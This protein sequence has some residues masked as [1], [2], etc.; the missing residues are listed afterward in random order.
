MLQHTSAIRGYAIEA[1]D[2][3]VGDITDFLVDD[4]T[5][6]MRWLVADTGGFLG[7]RKVL[8]PPSALG[9]V[10]HLGRRLS[11][12][13]TLRQVEDSPPTRSDEPVSRVMEANIYAYY[14][15][16]PYWSTGFDVGED[17]YPAGVTTR[18]DLGETP[19]DR[20]AS[21]ERRAG[22]DERLRSVREITGYHIH[23][24]DGGIGHVADFLI[25][26]WDWRIRYLVVDTRNWWHGRKVLVSTRSIESA[27]WSRQTVN[28][29]IDRQSIKVSPD[30]STGIEGA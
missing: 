7:D 5:W 26:D 6:R 8:I 22:A 13:L 2:G 1:S 18:D 29:D 11:V 27:D 28:L 21:I 30:D 19:R 9:H 25:E 17:G 23:A 12:D 15:W 20:L 4:T 3:P 10:D 14:G 24:R 16:S